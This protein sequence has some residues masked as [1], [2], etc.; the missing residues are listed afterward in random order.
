MMCMLKIITNGQKKMK[1]CVD[2]FLGVLVFENIR[3]LEFLINKRVNDVLI[4]TKLLDQISA[5]GDYLKL[6]LT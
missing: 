5:C 3:N 6:G 2:Y 1:A 4:R